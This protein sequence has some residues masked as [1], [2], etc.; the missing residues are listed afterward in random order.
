MASRIHVAYWI[1]T[2]SACVLLAACGKTLGGY[3]NH[4]PTASLVAPSTSARDDKTVYLDLIRQMQQQGAYYAS[5]AHIDAYRQRYGDAP[6]LRRRQ[7]DALRATGQLDAARTIYRGLLS[8]DQAAAAW[9]G[10]GLVD[11]QS[12]NPVGAD[13]ALLKATELE[14]VNAAYLSDLGYARLCAGQATTAKDPLAM[15]AELDPTNAKVIA[16]LALWAML[17]GDTT[18]ADAIMQRGQLP[19]NSQDD[20]RRLAVQLASRQRQ[21]AVS[22]A[23]VATPIAA[24]TDIRSTSTKA[25]VPASMLQRFTT[26]ATA[27][28]ARP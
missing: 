24:T 8:G 27:Y 20:V 21:A 11:A 25:D 15:A 17:T 12:N 5:L 22:P 9:H 18:R 4:A 16:N 7:A 14:P 19:A 6:E 10:L 26:D 28:E 3:P 23:R 2:A 1:T 13:E